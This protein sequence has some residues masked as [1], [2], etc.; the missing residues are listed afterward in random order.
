MNKVVTS[1]GLLLACNFMWAL[2]FT[3]VKLVQDQVGPYAT[4][5]GPMFLS[6]LL[7]MPFVIRELR[8]NRRSWR[9]VVIFI[10]LGLLGALPAQL[11]VTWGTQ[12][13]TASNAAVITLAL[14]VISS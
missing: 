14:P 13:S 6:V 1:W 4:V 3:C 9:D 10:R 2:Q 8:R 11:F 7:L 12:L 5:W